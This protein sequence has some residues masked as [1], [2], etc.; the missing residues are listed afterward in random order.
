MIKKLIIIIS[1]FLLS[2]NVYA[3]DF[4]INSSSAIVLADD[5]ILYQK[6]SDKVT[7]IASLTKIMTAVVT[8]ENT[9]D[10]NK[11]V[12]ITKDDVKDIL[13]LDLASASLKEGDVVSINDLLYGLMLPSGGDAAYALARVVG[14]TKENFVSMMNKTAEKLALEHTH[15]TNPVGF[16]EQ[17]NFSTARDLSTLFSY[18][19]ENDTFKKIVTTDTYLASDNYH[20]YT[21]HIRKNS[22]VGDYL[23]GGK[24]GTTNDA[25]LCLASFAYDKGVRLMVITLNAPLDYASKPQYADAKTIYSY[26]IN[27]YDLQKVV[28][29]N[30]KVLSLSVSNAVKEF[31]DFHP[32]KDKYL[33]LPNDFNKEDLRYEYSGMKK[34]DSKIKKGDKIGHLNI[35]YKGEKI[36]SENVYL[37]DNIKFSYIVFMKNHIVYVMGLIIF[38]TLLFIVRKIKKTT[39]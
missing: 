39:K 21:S 6:E 8:I 33:Y 18:A 14:G 38:T 30:E 28:K 37:E 26:Y 32:V 10:L 9:D 24:T 17:N 1:L 31:M 7:K 16:D 29:T 23:E 36:Y 5:K 34:L 12:T 2:I 11:K 20:T 27:N 19:L 22:L 35:L 3:K 25:G 15:F 4:N 13:A